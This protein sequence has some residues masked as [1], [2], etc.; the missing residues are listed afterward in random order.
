MEISRLFNFY[1]NY[2]QNNN[3]IDLLVSSVFKKGF[4]YRKV[5]LCCQLVANI[6]MERFRDRCDWRR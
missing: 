6:S 1:L 3:N 2:F 5:S 4:L